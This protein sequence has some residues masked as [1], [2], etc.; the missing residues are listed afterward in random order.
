[1]PRA[2]PRPGIVERDLVV[3]RALPIASNAPR[4]SEAERDI[5]VHVAVDEDLAGELDHGC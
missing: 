5:R 3:V 1:M 2:A 4:A